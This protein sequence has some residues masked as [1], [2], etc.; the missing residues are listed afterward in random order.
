MLEQ[1][2]REERSHAEFSWA[3]AE[4]AARAQR[5]TRCEP[6]LEQALARLD[7][8]RRP[9]AVS[10]HKQ[11]LV[12]RADPAQLRRHGRL[13]DERWGELWRERLT[14]TRSRARELSDVAGNALAP[15]ESAG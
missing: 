8:Y 10:W 5:A 1:I 13:P 3:V 9:T 14:A 4:L 2:A 15:A 11:P 12:A 7:R 6:A